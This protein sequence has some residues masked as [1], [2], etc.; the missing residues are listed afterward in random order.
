MRFTIKWVSMMSAPVR[1]L[2]SNVL[3]VQIKTKIFSF[4]NVDQHS[5]LSKLYV[6]INIK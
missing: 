4:K 1:R 5:M 6:E 3:Y 2:E